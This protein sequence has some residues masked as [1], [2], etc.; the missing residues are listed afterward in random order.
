MSKQIYIT[1]CSKRKAQN[2]D[3]TTM[4]LPPELYI[5]PRIQEFIKFCKLYN[6]AWAVFS[7][8][9]G[10]VFENEKIKWYDKSPDYVTSEEYQRLLDI[11]LIKLTDYDEVVFYYKLDTYHVL[12]RNLVNDLKKFKNIVLLDRLE[13][14][15]EK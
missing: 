8:Y 1:Y 6:L 15:D 7:D 3:S 13:M 12:Y 10:L 4:Y 14:L 5:S 9:Y 2:T 11:T